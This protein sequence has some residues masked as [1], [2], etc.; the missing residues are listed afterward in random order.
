MYLKTCWMAV[1]D[2]DDSAILRILKANEFT[3]PL[4]GTVRG[5]S[6]VVS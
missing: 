4:L 2:Q 1:A 5:T 6:D 3:D